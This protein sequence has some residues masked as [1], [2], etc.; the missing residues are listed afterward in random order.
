VMGHGKV[1]WLKVYAVGCVWRSFLDA[2]GMR[3]WIARIISIERL[4]QV[5]DAGETH[6]G[7]RCFQNKAQNRDTSSL[8]Y[9]GHPYEL[10]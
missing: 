3:V 10:E 8:R 2:L 9:R 1:V 6:L 4:V 5:P 7:R